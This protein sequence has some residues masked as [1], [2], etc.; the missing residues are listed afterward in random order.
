MDTIFTDGQLTKMIETMRQKGMNPE[1][2]N[3]L[4]SSGIFAD[5]CDPN[6]CFDDRNSVRKAL[7]LGILSESTTLSVDY[8]R[9]LEEMIAVGNYDWKNDIITAEQF[10]VVGEGVVQYEAKLCHFDRAISS[11][12]AVKAIQAAGFEPGDI[13][14][15]LSFGEKYSEEW[16]KYPIIAL[17]SV[18]GVRIR[19]FVP[20]LSRR[21]TGHSLDLGWWGNNWD[22][23]CRFL[24]VRKL[25][26]AA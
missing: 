15:L 3:G 26:S 19:R 24:V 8:S 1:R 14:H 4:L 13:E 12:A 10:P 5:V 6:A 23:H 18:A 17:G 22:D 21:N 20:C 2:F 11:G 16:R 25:F 9:S 7:K